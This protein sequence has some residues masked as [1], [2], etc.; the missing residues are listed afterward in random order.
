MSLT[1]IWPLF[2]APLVGYLIGGFPTAYIFSKLVAGVDPREFGSG[3]VSTRNTIRAAGLWPWGAI[4]FTIDGIKGMLACTIVEYFIAPLV[5]VD[6]WSTSG[7]FTITEIYVV[8]CA[9]AA[10]AGHCWMPY[11][12]F[13]GGKGLATFAG[14]LLYFYWPVAFFWLF[15]LLIMIKLSG[16]SGIGACWSVVFLSPFLYLIDV[17]ASQLSLSDLPLAFWPHSY[18]QDGTLG[19]PFILLYILGIWLVLTIRHIPE[20]R[21]IKRGEAKAWKNLKKTEM[22]K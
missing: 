22:L 14:T 21:R 11:M 16:F 19:W 5:P 17:I 2:V 4:C 18:F 20:F 9:I 1:W 7:S 13:R 10:I 12:K 6:A 15:M 3:S 8:L